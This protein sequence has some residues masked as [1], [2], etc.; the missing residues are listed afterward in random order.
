MVR[1]L[2]RGPLFFIL[3]L[4]ASIDTAAA[5]FPECTPLAN[6]PPLEPGPNG[7]YPAD[8]ALPIKGP[9]T[10]WSTDGVVIELK[11]ATQQQSQFYIQGV[12][13]EPNQIG[14]SASIPPFNDLFYTNSVNTWG[15]LWDR[16]IEALRAMGVNSI[17]TYGVWKWEPGFANGAP[18]PHNGQPVQDGVAD[19]WQLLDFTARAGTEAD[20]QFCDPDNPSIY[21]FKHPTH[22]P[23][24]DKLW[25]NGVNPI[26]VWLGLAVPLELVDPNISAARKANLRQFYRY[27]AKWLAKEYGNHPAVIGFVVDNEIDTPATTPT[28]AFWETLNDLNEVI[29]AS[30]NDKLTAVTF[31]DTADYARPITSG[32]FT[33]KTGPQVY[34]PDVWGFNPYTNPEPPG[35]L[36]TRFRDN[37][38]TVCKNPANGCSVKPLMYG[39]FGVTADTHKVSANAAKAYPFQWVAVNFIWQKNPPPAQC[40]TAQTMGPPPGSGGDGPLAEFNAQQTIA[41]ELPQGN[42]PYTLPTSLA[43]FFTKSG[44]PSGGPLAAADQADWIADFWKVTLNHKAS[45]GANRDTGLLYS[46][47]GYVFEWRDEWWKGNDNLNEQNTRCFHSI[48]GNQAC[49]TAWAGCPAGCADTGAANV[50]FPGGWGDEEWFGVTGAVVNGRQNCDPV[51]NQF[52]GQLNGGPDI[53]LPRAAINA[54]CQLFHSN[55]RCS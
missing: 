42:N 34:E 39:E 53:L 8:P 7:K 29:K 27:T 14:G 41:V 19:F 6:N 16:D 37:V 46:S 36:F 44:I 55:G 28:S 15:P 32:T 22:L 47:G 31:H 52:T 43:S 48:S 23:F 2:K 40:L 12:N 35:N 49:G 38:A 9:D 1:W 25:N 21:A 13:Y 50:V 18:P 3:G 20:N 4:L 10:K 51:V 26:Y 24:L 5:A 54:L 30:T 45:N 33:G 11:F 17:R